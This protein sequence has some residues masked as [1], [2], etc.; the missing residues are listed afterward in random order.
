ML[1]RHAELQAMKKTGGGVSFLIRLSDTLLDLS[2]RMERGEITSTRSLTAAARADIAA[3]EERD[4]KLRRRIRFKATE[5]GKLVSMSGFRKMRAGSTT[6]TGFQV[7]GGYINI[8]LTG[9]KAQGVAFTLRYLPLKVSE[10]S[11]KLGR[12]FESEALEEGGH[13]QSE[14]LKVDYARRDKALRS[15]V[16]ALLAEAR[17]G[18]GA[19][20]ARL[21]AAIKS[22]RNRQ[23]E[24]EAPTDLLTA[25]QK[26]CLREARGKYQREFNKVLFGRKQQ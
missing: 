7:P 13:P 14:K 1:H 22:I 5:A 17:K 4:A 16:D 19:E 6:G 3:M 26:Q 23:K 15:A 10:D 21:G 9:L 24:A 12:D 11:Y 25:E 18:K 20:G 2:K 8:E